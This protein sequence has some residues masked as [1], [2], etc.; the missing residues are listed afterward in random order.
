[1]IV[2][3]FVLAPLRG[4]AQ[5]PLAPTA[6]IDRSQSLP[7]PLSPETIDLMLARMTDAEIRALLQA[8]LRAGVTASGGEPSGPPAF[9]ATR[10]DRLAEDLSVRVPAMLQEIVTLPARWSE[11]SER[12]ATARYG[13]LGMLASIVGLVATGILAAGAV[14]TLTRSW[15]AWLAAGARTYGDRVVRTIALGLVEFAPIVAFVAATRVAHAA[16]LEALGPMEAWVW[17]YHT[18]VSYAWMALLVARRAFAPDAPL[19]RVAPF[20]D[21]EASSIVD[22]VR[23]AVTIAAAGWLIAGLFPTLGLG[24]APAILTVAIC[25]TGVAVLLAMAVVRRR[26]RIGE[27]A[28]TLVSSTDGHDGA[29]GPVLAAAAPIVL[30]AYIAGA[31]GYWLLLWLE[32]GQPYLAGPAG[33]LVVVLVAPIADRM[34][35]EAI[36]SAIS[37]RDPRAVRVV[38]ALLDAWRFLVILVAALTILRLWGLDL[39]AAAYGPDASRWARAA[40]DIAVAVFLGAVSWRLIRAALHTE[41][42]VAHGGEDADDPAGGGASRLDTLTP[43][44]RAM[45]LGFIGITVAMIVLSALGLNIGPLIAS[46]GIVG[47]AVG[48][49]AQTLVRDI[50]SGIFFLID[51]AFRI[52]EYIEIDSDTRGEVEAI[53]VRSL[54][55]RHHRGSVITVPFGE[56][57]KIVNHNRDWVIYK[58]AFRLELDT[59]PERVKKVVKAVAAELSQHPEHGP[60]LLEPLKSQG[61]SSID[62][63]SALVIHVKFKSK[64]RAQFVLRREVYHRLRTA[65]AAAGIEF[66]RRKVEVVNQSGRPLANALEEAVAG[67][68]MP[69]RAPAA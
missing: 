24:Y 2:V 46:A 27:A 55:L 37:A 62:E 13:L 10:L 57:K 3:L 16:L 9:A 6:A 65:F 60:N 52:G 4:G 28:A 32:S 43:L 20:S 64:P 50:F 35:R 66:A 33:T 39:F 40:F 67:A 53:T 69:P 30:L 61:V 58:M 29:L 26:Q 18:G 47:I 14:S 31:W 42:R 12:I 41:A 34:G 19:I 68:G 1:M 54:Q 22:V 49:G 38:S 15:R 44:F 23:R 25:G 56:L 63:D 45:L 59:D 7:R 36:S 21:A 48:F 51:D 8:E 5:A 11:V 17:I